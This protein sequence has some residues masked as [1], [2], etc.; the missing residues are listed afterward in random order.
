MTDYDEET[1][2]GFLNFHGFEASDL[3]RDEL[4]ELGGLIEIDEVYRLL[5]LV[6]DRIKKRMEDELCDECQFNMHK[7]IEEELG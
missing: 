7:I 5:V 4:D 1:V 2:D 3:T 6:R